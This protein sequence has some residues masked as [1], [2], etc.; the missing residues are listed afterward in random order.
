LAKS[1]VV[2]VPVGQHRRARHLLVDAVDGVGVSVSGDEDDNRYVAYLSEPPRG[3]DPFA[4][5]FEI[6]VRQDNIGRI[7]H[8]LQKGILSICR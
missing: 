2:V 1:F 6:Y 4:A 7:L 8:C 5:S 3:L